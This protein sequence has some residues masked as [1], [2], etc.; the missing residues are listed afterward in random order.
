M[1]RIF[2]ALLA[3]PLCA[4]APA[5][6]CFEVRST[7]PP[8]VN[9]DRVRQTWLTWNNRLRRRLQLEPY[10]LEDH[11]N[12]TAANW[13]TYAVQRGT[14]DHKR[15][16]DAAYYDYGA[17]ESWFAQKGL[18]FANVDGK[19][20]TENIGWGTYQC[21]SSDCTTQLIDS[22]RST[23]AFFLSERGKEYRPHYNS[24]VNPAFRKI[25]LGIA[26]SPQGRYYLTVH[27]ATAITSNPAP[28]CSAP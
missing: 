16:A 5:S 13:S 12:S 27:Y 11:L 19:T 2:L 1:R 6:A 18:T 24:I 3:V 28:V 21:T 4:A 17:I 20:F 25:G 22:I 8:H 14:I 10:V 9:M 7:P 15:S 23:F 26:V